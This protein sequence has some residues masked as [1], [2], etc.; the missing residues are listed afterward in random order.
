LRERLDAAAGT[1]TPGMAA[2]APSVAAAAEFV[3][4][5]PV[6]APP[7]EEPAAGAD[8]AAG[9]APNVDDPDAEPAPITVT[10]DASEEHPAEFGDV[11]PLGARHE[12]REPGA[13]AR[14]GS[15]AAESETAGER[16]ADAGAEGAPPKAPFIEPKIPDWLEGIRPDGPPSA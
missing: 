2:N 1:A 16:R 14:G 13:H 4:A 11:G 10:L 8:R 6:P 5:E 15:A 9:A 3:G 12:A 7:L